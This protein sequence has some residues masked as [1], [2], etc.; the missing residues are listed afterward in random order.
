MS[1]MP[2]SR[3]DIACKLRLKGNGYRTGSGSDRII[4]SSLE[5]SGISELAVES[6]IRS[7]PLAVLYRDLRR[8]IQVLTPDEYSLGFDGAS[9]EH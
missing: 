1:A 4:H 2:V 5:S 9:H 7:L 8:Q 6:D 3:G